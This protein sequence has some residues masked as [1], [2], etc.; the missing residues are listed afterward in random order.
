MFFTLPWFF[1]FLPHVTHLKHS[2]WRGFPFIR[3]NTP[4]KEEIFTNQ[5]YFLKN[6]SIAKCK[7]HAYQIPQPQN[8]FDGKST[9]DQVM[10]W[11]RQATSHYLSQCRP[12]CIS[13]YGVTRPQWVNQVYSAIAQ[14]E[15]I[16][17]HIISQGRTAVSQLLTNWRYCCLVH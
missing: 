16:H 6:I 5:C 3:T 1:R 17:L 11:C 12:R 13:A 14:R 7:S 8:T 9:L 10:A 2:G 4:L 15:L